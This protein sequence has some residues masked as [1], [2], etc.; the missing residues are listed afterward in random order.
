MPALRIVAD[1]HS[2]VPVYRQIIEQI[3]F[4]IASGLLAP[5]DEL[6]STR[7]LSTQLALN[8]M[9]VSK[10]YSLLERDGLVE[11][12]AGLPLVVRMRRGRTVASE[13]TDQ[14]TRLLAP[15]VRAARQL[16]V[17]TDDAVDTFRELLD[18]ADR[19]KRGKP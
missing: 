1:V 5:G 17:S 12:R 11:R 3:R 16:G 6:P 14:L 4:H 8:P 13:Q 10:A 7:A 15:A 2:G 18:A 9:T 19:T